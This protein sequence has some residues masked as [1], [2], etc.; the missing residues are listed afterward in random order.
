MSNSRTTKALSALDHIATRILNNQWGTAEPWQGGDVVITPK[1]LPPTVGGFYP[2]F[3]FVETPY[4]AELSWLFEQSRDAVWK[5]DGYGAWKEEF[6]GRLGNEADAIG[7]ESPTARRAAAF[8]S[9]HAS[10]G[11]TEWCLNS[12]LLKECGLKCSRLTIESQM[13]IWSGSVRRQSPCETFF[14]NEGLQSE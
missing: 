14:V 2:D 4:V 12:T 10:R 6:F 9:R 1:A 3:R 8:A 7:N 5:L 13:M 11:Y